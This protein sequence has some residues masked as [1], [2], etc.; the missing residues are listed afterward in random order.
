MKRICI[1]FISALILIA[2]IFAVTVSAGTDTVVWVNPD[3]HKAP[4]DDYAYSFCVVGDTQ[5]L[6]REDGKTH[7]INEYATPPEYTAKIYDWI[8]DNV[9]EK[10]IAYVMGL[11]DI[12][13]TANSVD[14]W[15]VAKEQIKRLNGVVPYSLVRGNHD[16]TTSFT[17]VVGNENPE[18]VETLEGAF[19]K[20]RAAVL[21]NWRTLRVG[22]VSY[23]IM[24]LDY[25]PTDAVLE[26]ANKVIAE[27][28]HHRVIITTHGYL[29]TNSTPI[30]GYD[31]NYAPHGGNSGKDI[32][33]KLGKKHE[34]IFMIISGHVATDG[35]LVSSRQGE[36]KNKVYELLID[37][38]GL[39]EEYISKKEDPAGL[40]AMFYFSKD[41][42]SIGLEYYSTVRR[43]YVD[44]FKDKISNITPYVDVLGEVETEAPQTTAIPE[45]T[46]ALTDNGAETTADVENKGC[47]GSISFVALP[48][49]ISALGA[50][51]AASKK[52]KK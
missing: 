38:Q 39:D 21:N 19:E 24:V 42:K 3:D 10:K 20:G 16:D 32:W 52:R 7:A 9:E 45:T 31:K 5:K 34:N 17:R 26:W 2:L 43:A 48:V 33:N 6:M 44:L 23:L 28:P 29:N 51:M 15:A 8:I 11:G 35:I 14:E 1:S 36:N 4:L 47:K 46:A 40:V 50:A 49:T 30:S 13:Q 37:G 41:G 27:H 25:Y 22:G 12:C 18:Y